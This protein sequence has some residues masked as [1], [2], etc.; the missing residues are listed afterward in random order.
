VA[1]NSD[2]AI[3]PERTFEDGLLRRRICAADLGGTKV[4]RYKGVPKRDCR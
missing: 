4:Q 3:R 2:Q 1:P